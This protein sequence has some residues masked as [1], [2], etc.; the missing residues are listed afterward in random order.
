MIWV[1]SINGPF[2]ILLAE[3]SGL[4]FSGKC[5]HLIAL[6]RCNGWTEGAGRPIRGSKTVMMPVGQPYKVV[7]S[8]FPAN[9]L[10][11]NP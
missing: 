4:V 9:A 11:L 2:N 8:L 10:A 3:K 1:N 5:H 6:R 7:C